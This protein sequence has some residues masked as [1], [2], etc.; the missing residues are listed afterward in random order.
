MKELGGMIRAF[1]HN[2]TNRHCFYFCIAMAV[3]GYALL[4]LALIW[5]NI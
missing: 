4:Y 1:W 2:R 3:L 5:K